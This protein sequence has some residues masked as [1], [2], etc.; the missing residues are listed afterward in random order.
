MKFNYE[1]SILVLIIFQLLQW[2]F[3][4]NKFTNKS[5]LYEMNML[6]FLNSHLK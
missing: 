4:N 3:Q 1:K 5:S 6:L 2:I